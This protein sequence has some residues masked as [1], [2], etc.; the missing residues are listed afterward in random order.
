MLLR[1]IWSSRSTSECV[2]LLLLLLRA[3]YNTYMFLFA[4]AVFIYGLSFILSLHTSLLLSWSPCLCFP[5]CAFGLQSLYSKKQHNSKSL[6]TKV[7]SKLG[8][9]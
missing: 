1:R 6:G 9:S 8:L 7:W 2:C 5:C 4:F 3:C